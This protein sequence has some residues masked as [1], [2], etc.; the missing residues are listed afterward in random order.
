MSKKKRVESQFIH[1][2]Q[3]LI[4]KFRWFFNYCPKLNTIFLVIKFQ[5]KVEHLIDRTD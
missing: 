2:F 4:K 1:L 5:S 3:M